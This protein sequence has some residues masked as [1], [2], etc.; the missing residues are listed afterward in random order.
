MNDNPV[1]TENAGSIHVRDRSS[2]HILIKQLREF[3]QYGVKLLMT[4]A[5]NQNASFLKLL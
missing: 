4:M 1:P 2:G 5:R 3:N